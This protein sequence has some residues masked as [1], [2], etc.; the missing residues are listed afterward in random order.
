MVRLGP[1]ARRFC[2]LCARQMGCFRAGAKLPS[3]HP[4]DML[5]SAWGDRGHRTGVWANS[6]RL[7]IILILEDSGR[8]AFQ[9]IIVVRSPGLAPPQGLSPLVHGPRHRELGPV[10][11]GS[12]APAGLSCPHACVVCVGCSQGVTPVS[13][14]P[15]IS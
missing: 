7:P 8:K 15:C 4:Q 13:G 14:G 2:G 10:S 6:R 12:G 11:Q 5:C 9:N 1:A 3:W